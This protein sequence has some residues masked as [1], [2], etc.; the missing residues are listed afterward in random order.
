MVNRILN[1]K[2]LPYLFRRSAVEVTV[3]IIDA[4]LQNIVH[5]SLQVN[6]VYEIAVDH[7]LGFGVIGQLLIEILDASDT[8]EGLGVQ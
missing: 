4:C 1:E 5:Y 6:Y 7:Q 2:E 3:V 8:G